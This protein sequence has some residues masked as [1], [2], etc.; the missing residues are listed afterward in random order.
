[1]AVEC[2]GGIGRGGVAGP[3]E[4]RGQ[5]LAPQP[6]DKHLRHV[7]AAIV[8]DIDDHPFFADLR[9]IPLDELADALCLHVGDVDIADAAVVLSRATRSRL[10]AT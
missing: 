6:L 3:G 1:M 4:A 10:L 5:Q 9:I 8:A 2:P 7:S